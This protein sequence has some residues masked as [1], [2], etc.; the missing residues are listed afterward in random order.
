MVYTEV[1]FFPISK[2]FLHSF[3]ILERGYANPKSELSEQK[4]KFH[5]SY[6]ICPNGMGGGKGKN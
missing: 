3:W 1:R 4:K 2:F 5:R 6:L